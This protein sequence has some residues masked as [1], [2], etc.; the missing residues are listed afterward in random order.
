MKDYF[1]S[2]WD[3]ELYNNDMLC[4]TVDGEEVSR[5]ELSQD[6]TWK[7]NSESEWYKEEEEE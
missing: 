1:R 6:N 7:M 5:E 2:D 4:N 3:G